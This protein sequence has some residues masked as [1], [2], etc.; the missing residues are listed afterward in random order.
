MGGEAH[1]GK[2]RGNFIQ[3]TID[4]LAETLERSLY[5]EQLAEGGGLL[6]RLDP[7]V[8]L[9]AMLG[10]IICSAASPARPTAVEVKLLLS[11]NS[12]CG[13]SAA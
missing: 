11:E 4:A 1:H 3:R 12:T 7:R 13:R 10:F 6:Q 8:K 2:R 5:A 9:V